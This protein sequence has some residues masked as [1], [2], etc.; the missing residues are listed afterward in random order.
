MPTLDRCRHGRVSECWRYIS[1]I[2]PASWRDS[3]DERAGRG[4]L[5]AGPVSLSPAVSSGRPGAE[6]FG[7]ERTGDDPGACP[8]IH[9]PTTRTGVPAPRWQADPIS[10]PSGL[11]GAARHRHVLPGLSSAVAW[12]RPRPRADPYGT[13]ARA[14]SLGALATK[15]AYA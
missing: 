12:H 15:P 6:L 9:R 10:W 5:E 4:V 13:R 1:G 3:R 14:G 7:G 11:C 2:M 8:S